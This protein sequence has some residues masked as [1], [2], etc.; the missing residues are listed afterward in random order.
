VDS[1]L[2]RT[3]WEIGR[4]IA[5]FEQQGAER[6]RYGTRLMTKLAKTLTAEFGKGFDERNRRHM[7]TFFQGFQIWNAVRTELS[8]THYLPSCASKTNRL[9]IG[10]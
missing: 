4:H 5:L 9:A 10:I 2:V 7:R 3:C 1:I 8:W 6:T